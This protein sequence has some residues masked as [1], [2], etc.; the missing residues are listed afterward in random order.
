M[1]RWPSPRSFH[2]HGDHLA[3]QIVREDCDRLAAVVSSLSQR[4]QEFVRLYFIDG[5]SPQEIAERLGLNVK[6]VYTKKHRLTR[7][8]RESFATQRARAATPS[9]AVPVAA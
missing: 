2:D 3:H 6:S 4:D 5:L 7:Q 9:S 8:L 1:I